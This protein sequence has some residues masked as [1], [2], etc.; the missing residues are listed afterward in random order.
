M[1]S[2][3]CILLSL[4]AATL[5]C[6][7][8]CK[9]KKVVAPPHPAT[10][11]KT[12]DTAGKNDSARIVASNGCSPNA[13]NLNDGFEIHTKGIQAIDVRYYDTAGTLIQST[14]NLSPVI[15][16][17][18]LPM[19]SGYKPA[20]RGIQATT[21]MGNKIGFWDSVYMMACIPKHRTKASFGFADQ[22]IPT[23]TSWQFAAATAEMITTCP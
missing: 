8:S 11:N 7:S 16:Y 3:H 12:T 17:F 2:L 20:L 22:I 18:P 13:D 21:T 9:D 5:V 14:V 1:K 4:L 23:A 19:S 6:C 10:L 15:T